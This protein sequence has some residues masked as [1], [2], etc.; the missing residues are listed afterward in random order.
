MKQ[1]SNYLFVYG[2]LL[3]DD[4]EFA[5]YLNK[6][7]TFYRK[8]KFK[9]K[10]YDLGEYPGAV[11]DNNDGYVHGS[12]FKLPYQTEAFKYLDD[13]EGFGNDQEQPNLFIRK[14]IIVETDSGQID[15]WVY[16]YNLS[17][18]DFKL[19]ASG[20]YREYKNL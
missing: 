14:V 19:I 20:D 18:T 1:T 2:T 5:I 7:C 3:N 12:T 10:L 13:Y 15:C 9:G 16:L 17:T 6:Y 8:G 11:L 4:N